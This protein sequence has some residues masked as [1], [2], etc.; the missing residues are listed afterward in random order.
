MDRTVSISRAVVP[1]KAVLIR[2]A[3]VERTVPELTYI[4][5]VHRRNE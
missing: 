3:V 1:E 5:Q 2:R 4:L